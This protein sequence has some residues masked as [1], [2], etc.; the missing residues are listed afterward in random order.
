ML[1]YKGYPRV[2]G[3]AGIRNTILVISGDLCC[4]PWSIEIASAFDHCCAILHKHGVGNYSPDR[5]LFKHIMSGITV[6]PNV[7]GFVFV[8]SGNE[9]HSPGEILY[10][11]ES[12][13]KPFHI[14]SAA[15]EN[16]GA[17]V[18][19]KGI[20][21]VERL[22]AD[23]AN[24]D[25]VDVGI[26][27]LRIGLNCAG[28]DTVSAKTVHPVCAALS[29]KIVALGGTIFI[30]E[31]PDLIGLGDIVFDRC[32][33]VED[34]ERLIGFYNARRKLLTQTGEIIDDIE[35]V[36]FNTEGGLK[37]LRQK[38][39]VSILKAGTT[40][41]REVLDYGDTPSQ[42][43]LV[44]MD[45][46]AMTDFVMTGYMASGVHIMINTCGAGEGNKMPFTVGADTPSAILP[47]I[48]MTGGTDHYKEPSNRIDFDATTVLSGGESID[49]AAERLLAMILDTASGKPTMTE[50][51]RDYMLNI[52]M[53]FHQA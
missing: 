6:N 50:V 13:G 25:R 42:N 23:A 16:C 40:P 8:S 44:F 5:N 18:V 12:A 52:P 20:A 4:N 41:I 29:D 21:Y 26:D 53:R 11:A 46:P 10:R 38:A 28:T 15:Q 9:D 34:R 2:R 17:D 49:M 45:G 36:A 3:P 35:M 31:T 51:P 24:T 47:I 7:Y 30:S 27:D 33:H 32:G 48:K 14:V 39:E 37:T 1:T 43:G 19:R 22:L